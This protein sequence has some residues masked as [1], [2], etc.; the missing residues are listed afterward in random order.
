[1]WE[2][3]GSYE[4]SPRWLDLLG[5][6]ATVAAVFFAA[7]TIRRQRHESAKADLLY[8]QTVERTSRQARLER[9]LTFELGLL[10]EIADT[11]Y[12]VSAGVGDRAARMQ[13]AMV[14]IAMFPPTDLPFC[15]RHFSMQDI[16]AG[17]KERLAQV[18]AASPLEQP[19]A[20]ERR[21]MM[22]EITQAI[23][24]RRD[25]IPPEIGTD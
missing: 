16:P 24:R 2:W 20:L 17:T 6:S 11:A 5:A 4:G 23:Y 13:A 21:E 9:Q 3:L 8:R 12:G 22:R 18:V 14:R 25:K 19:E 1:M 15:R 10:V 7:F